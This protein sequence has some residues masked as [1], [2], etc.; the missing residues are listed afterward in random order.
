M[1]KNNE[2]RPKSK[3]E[4]D[5]QHNDT[6]KTQSKHPT[7]TEESIHTEKEQISTQ[8]RSTQVEHTKSEQSKHISNSDKN[9]TENISDQQS[10]ESHEQSSN[11]TKIKSL[12]FKRTLENFHRNCVNINFSFSKSYFY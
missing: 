12:T 4:K 2:S 7:I 10:H 9:T 5:N 3:Q 1:N 11:D 8:Q 6:I